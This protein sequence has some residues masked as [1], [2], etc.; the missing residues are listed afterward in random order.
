MTSNG[1]RLGRLKTGTCPRLDI[2]TIDLDRLTEQ[3]PDEPAPRFAFGSGAPSLPQV[4]CYHTRTTAK[5][6][7]IIASAVERGLAPLYN[8]QLDSKGPRYCPSIEDKVIRFAHNDS[9]QV[10]LEPQGLDTP[11]VYPAGLSTSL[12]PE[13]QLEFLHAID[14]LEQAEVTR[15]GYAVEYDF[16]DPIQL[17]PS[18]ETKSIDC[19][20]TAGQLN[21]TTGYEEAAIQGFIAGVNAS[22]SL[23]K[24]PPLVLG[25]HEAYAGVLVDDLV[26]LGTD[27]PYRMFTSRAEH[28]LILREDNAY[29]RLVQKGNEL[30]LL[31][32]SRF[33]RI[34]ATEARVKEEIARARSVFVPVSQAVNDALVA[35]GSSPLKQGQSLDQLLLRPEM[36]VD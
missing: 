2:R 36:T 16:V 19:L 17:H 1:L 11:E 31:D 30:G 23:E 9:H 24:K 6:H 26:T 29:A 13:V 22:L 12:P 27:E 33:E 35:A 32:A 14:G 3:P 18:L 10:F 20:F 15:W 4:S 25:R 28:R 5:S 21:G 8:G 7:Q 34:Q